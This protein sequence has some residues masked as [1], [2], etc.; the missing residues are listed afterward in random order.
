[1]NRIAFID[2]GSNS[3][4]YVV[5]E[6]A[7]NL[8]YKLIYQQKD[9]IRLSEGLCLENKLI[10]V[11]IARALEALQSF[12]NIGEKLAVNKTIA[13]AT[14]AV[15]QAVNGEEFINI[16]KQKTGFKLQCIS[17][18]EE[19][20][21]GFIGVANT[22]DLNDYIMF[23][24]GGA[25]TEVSLIRN[26]QI[27]Q[28]HSFPF[29]ALILKEQF[30]KG[31]ELT[32]DEAVKMNRYIQKQLDEQKWLKGVKLP[33]IGIGGT[34]RNIGKM[35]QKNYN[36]PISKLHNY[37]IG[38]D[39]F[40]IL[41]DTL[42][43]LNI[44]QRKKIP[45]LSSER[46]DI[47]I[48]GMSIINNLLKY[49]KGNKLIISGSGLREGLF[50]D[51]YG[52][53]YRHNEIILKDP[54]EHSAK[55]YLLNTSLCADKHS[56]TKLTTD[57]FN[58]LSPLHDY[59]QRLRTLLHISTTFH[60]IG[61][62]V[63]YYSYTKHTI[64]MLLNAPL[65]GLTHREQAML[66]FISGFSQGVDQKLIN[67]FLSAQLLNKNDWKIVRKLSLIL[68][69]AITLDEYYKDEIQSIDTFI[70]NENVYLTIFLKENTGSKFMSSKLEKIKKQFKKEYGLVLHFIESHI[71][72]L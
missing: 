69:I 65:Y 57:L 58:Q 55:N 45:G 7:D 18:I 33:I 5:M 54:L 22:I 31:R 43:T 37:E 30:Q 64:Y 56:L 41:N 11:A 16:V 3:V 32:E 59:S 25:S 71:Q 46:A 21:L 13:V 28:S 70:K 1:M 60:D 38:L 42:S 8:S 48:H 62:L 72:A 47:I 23:D 49:C 53:H 29:G 51:Y 26:R 19:A 52:Q 50:Y 12:A 2:L 14:A 15:R 34:V 40:N 20:R 6:I 27:V 39:S 67:R 63:N 35:I 4:R 9:S 66:A 36:Y 24:L 61:Q 10:P 44:T 17:G 68:T